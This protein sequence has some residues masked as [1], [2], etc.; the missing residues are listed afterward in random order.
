MKE[1][2]FAV[3]TRPARKQSFAQKNEILIGLG[4]FLT[5]PYAAWGIYNPFAL[6]HGGPL[7]KTILPFAYAE[8]YEVVMLIVFTTMCRLLM[9]KRPFS[10]SLVNAM[11]WIGGLFTAAAVLIPR[12]PGYTSRGY[13][14]LALSEDFILIDGQ[15]F[16]AGMLFLILARLVKEGFEMQREMDEI[17]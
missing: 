17:L 15:L 13:D 1:N 16:V 11:Q 2:D 14:I 5:L 7:S 12:L 8:L 6:L 10:K 4:I 3:D 9:N